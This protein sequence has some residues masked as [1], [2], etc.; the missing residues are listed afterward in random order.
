MDR[1]ELLARSAC[2]VA[3]NSRVLA[4]ENFLVRG[5]DET[6]KAEAEQPNIRCCPEMATQ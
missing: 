6:T 1:A 4:F 3:E 2:Q 5:E